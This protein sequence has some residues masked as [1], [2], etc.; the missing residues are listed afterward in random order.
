MKINRQK[1]NTYKNRHVTSHKEIPESFVAMAAWSLCLAPL[2]RPPGPLSTAT[3]LRGTLGSFS[4]PLPAD[5]AHSDV[6]YVNV[7]KQ[8]FNKLWPT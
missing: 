6:T 8:V 7:T 3:A 5:A 2:R 4:P 1:Y